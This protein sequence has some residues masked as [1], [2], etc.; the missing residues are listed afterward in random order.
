MD[1][2]AQREEGRSM[3]R[4]SSA[5]AYRTVRRVAEQDVL[6]LTAAAP[7][8]PSVAAASAAL[9]AATTAED[10]IDL[11]HLVVAAWCDLRLAVADDR[12]VLVGDRW[13]PWEELGCYRGV[14]EAVTRAA[15]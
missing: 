5:E 8:F 7:C 10:V 6:A 2:A 15:R 14:V 1:G 12:L 4:D 3:V 13:V 11:E 9:R